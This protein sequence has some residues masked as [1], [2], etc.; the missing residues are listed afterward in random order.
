MPEQVDIGI[1]GAAGKR[2]SN[3][4]GLANDE[5]VNIYAVCDVQANELQRVARKTDANEMYTEYQ[6]MLGDP[7]LDALYITT[8]DPLHATQAAAA[9]KR[10]IHVLSEVPAA[11]TLE[12]SRKLVDAY[13]DSNAVY[14]MN[15]ETIYVKNNTIIKN[16]VDEDLFGEIYYAE[17][18]Y[19]HYIIEYMQTDS[20]PWRRGQFERNG[21]TYPTHALAPI[22]LLWLPGDRITELTAVGSGH[23]H[24]DQ[25]GERYGQEDTTGFFAKTEEGR[26]IRVRQDFISPRPPGGGEETLQNYQLQGTKGCYEAARSTIEPNKIWLSELSDDHETW[27]TLDQL[28]G[29][30]MPNY[31]QNPPDSVKEATHGGTDYFIRQDFID[32]IVNSESVPVGIHES[33]DLTL[34]GLISERSLENDSEWREVPDSRQW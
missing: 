4:G 32:A 19:L 20:T 24:T 14:M 13:N 12:E 27:A 16:I 17:G 10:D 31:W 1:V 26:L 28:E 25:E 7:N 30:Y 15:E 18:E 21:V 9:L 29:A 23:H 22:L 34:P 11:T 6:T 2:A 8:P 33:M 5:R 3:L